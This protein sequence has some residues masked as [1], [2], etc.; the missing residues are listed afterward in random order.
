MNNLESR[1]PRKKQKKTKVSSSL[2]HTPSTDDDDSIEEVK[3]PA[4]KG[5][6]SFKKVS[7]RAAEDK[8]ALE[9]KAFRA[10]CEKEAQSKESDEEVLTPAPSDG[11]N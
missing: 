7:K 1:I 3:K 11:E 4:K 5:K 2:K 6:V 8:V 10:A 9:E